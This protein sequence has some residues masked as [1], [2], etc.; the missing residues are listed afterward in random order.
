MDCIVAYSK[1]LNLRLKLHWTNVRVVTLPS[2]VRREYLSWGIGP[3]AKLASG[4]SGA[5]GASSGSGA[6]GVSEAS[7]ASDNVTFFNPMNVI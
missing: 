4:A 3:T 6:S 1:L 2:L 7:E 5:S